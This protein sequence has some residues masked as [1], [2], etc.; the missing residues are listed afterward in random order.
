MDVSQQIIYRRTVGPIHW[1]K[2]QLTEAHYHAVILY[3][4]SQFV[5]H[6]VGTTLIL[7]RN[8]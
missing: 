8:F 2:N 7:E 3:L 1:N 4:A 5:A 6:L